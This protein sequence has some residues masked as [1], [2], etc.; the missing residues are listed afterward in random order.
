M[1]G[2]GPLSAPLER[3]LT[4]TV[5]EAWMGRLPGAGEDILF[6]WYVPTL[7][8]AICDDRDVMFVVYLQNDFGEYT[9]R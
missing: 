2:V 1:H 5:E 8:A 9:P 4:V 6:W 3:V 7:C